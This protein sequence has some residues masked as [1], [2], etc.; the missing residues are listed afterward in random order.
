MS[1]KA[2]IKC[3]Q[4][5]NNINVNEILYRQLESEISQKNQLERKKLKRIWKD[6]KQNT[7]KLLSF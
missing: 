5:G 7:K 4:C 1:E 2:S 6:K 3:P